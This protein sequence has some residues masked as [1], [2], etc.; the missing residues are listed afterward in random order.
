MQEKN[1][2]TKVLFRLKGIKATPQR[3]A[4][5]EAM[6]MLGHASA[7]AV[8]ETVKKEY[9]SMTLATVYNVLEFLEQSDL[10]S[11]RMS[12][13]NKMYYDINTTTHCHLYDV[14]DNTF[15]DFN[16]AELVKLVENHLASKRIRNFQLER[17]DLQI[18][19]TKKKK[20]AR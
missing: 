1:T 5:F 9:Q 16:D 10:L 20:A 8:F 3:I 12:S 13:N 19:G 15:V 18:V 14:E 4:V 7:D 6:R 11:R 2:P 17:F